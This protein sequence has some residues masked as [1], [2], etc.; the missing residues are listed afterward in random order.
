MVVLHEVLVN[1]EPRPVVLAVGLYEEA[2]SVTV[3]HGL[4]Q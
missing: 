2:A 4:E 1:A 3:D